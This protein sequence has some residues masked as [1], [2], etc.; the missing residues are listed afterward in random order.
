M[1]DRQ[2]VLEDFLNRLR[3]T[4]ERPGGTDAWGGWN[5]EH[6]MLKVNGLP[7]SADHLKRRLDE[8]FV[9][10]AAFGEAMRC[11]P[12]HRLTEDRMTNVVRDQVR[13]HLTMWLVGHGNDPERVEQAVRAFVTG[14]RIAGPTE[15]RPLTG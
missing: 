12:D 6:G 2:R 8:L 5:A 4:R 1:P 11:V 7:V 10:A 9:D 13:R 15:R 3:V 14:F